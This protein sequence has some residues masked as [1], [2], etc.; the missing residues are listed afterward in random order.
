[1]KFLSQFFSETFV[2][3][4]LVVALI[5]FIN[6]FDFWMTDALHMTILGLVVA[7]FALF[8]VY[9]WKEKPAD[10][11]EELHRS[12]ATRFGYTV[13]GTILLLGTVL[14]AFDHAIDPWLPTALAAM[15][16]AKI[17]GRIY[18]EKKF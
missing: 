4:A 11:R 3:T 1:M 6:P 9:L 15:V 14:Q 12:I 2:A 7:L 8:A 17:A 13:V 5:W 10:E 16:L 18:A